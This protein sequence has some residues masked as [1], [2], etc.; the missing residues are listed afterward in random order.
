MTDRRMLANA[1]RFLS[2]DAVQAANSGPPRA[3]M[4]MADI[5]EVLWYG[6]LR[7]NPNNPQWA[8]RDR[9]VL[10][11]GH[12][13]M[14]IYSL[15]HL[16]GYGVTIDEL[17]S[18]RQLHSR[19]P[20]HPE[21]GYTA[22]VETTTGPL[23]QEL[24]NAIGMALAE[25][26]LAAQFNRE[27]F[28]VIDH[29]TYCFAGDGYLMEGVSHEA[30][31]L[32]GTL[33]L[34]KLLVFYDDNGISI[35]EDV[36]GWFSDDTPVRFEAYGWQVIRSV[37][38]QDATEVKTALKTARQ[39][40]SRPTLICCRT[41][42]GFGSPSLAGSEKIHGAPLGDAEVEATRHAT[43]WVYGPYEIPEDIQLA[44]DAKKQGAKAQA[45]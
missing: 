24:A 45:E 17:K 1:I 29:S 11:N 20:G 4:G 16:T 22:G 14:L 32:A 7:H 37:D 35:D 34:G 25:R 10:S 18:F 41:V 2:V 6:V 43:G 3:P 21:Y 9:F 33:G 26:T 42:L 31:S 28:P 23:G 39:E 36:G 38:G 15:H 40:T 12:G 30:R 19:T 5:A 13:A 27:Q 44:W 8:N